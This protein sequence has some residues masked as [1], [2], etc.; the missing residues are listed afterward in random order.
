MDD[1]DFNERVNIDFTSFST[2]GVEETTHKDESKASINNAELLDELKD[3]VNLVK[4]LGHDLIIISADKIRLAY[5]EQIK[6]MQVKGSWV[7]PIGLF[8]TLLLSLLTAEFSDSFGIEKAVWKAFFLLG[9]LLTFLWAVISV[10]RSFS[11]TPIE[12][13]ESF[14]KRI[15]I[16]QSGK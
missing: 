15:T 16:D 4:V 5:S 2:F 7:A 12:D 9:C 8:L 13:V 14:I 6:L 1:K 10:Y 3:N 11:S